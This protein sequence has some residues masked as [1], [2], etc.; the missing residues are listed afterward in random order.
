MWGLA[1]VNTVH[2]PLQRI[3]VWPLKPQ[4]DS[5]RASTEALEIAKWLQVD[6]F[7]AN[8]ISFSLRAKSVHINAGVIARTVKTEI[9][10][11]HAHLFLSTVGTAVA[12]L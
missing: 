3:P 4:D 12:I 7:A 8:V 11:V 9:Y 6:H 10:P 5:C 1:E 2:E